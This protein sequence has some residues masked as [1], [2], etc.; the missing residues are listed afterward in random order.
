[1]AW[2][3]VESARPHATLWHGTQ[4]HAGDVCLLIGP[5]GSIL[6]SELLRASNMVTLLILYTDGTV[7]V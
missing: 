3:S 2:L 4:A 6:Y 7:Y 1:M 5:F